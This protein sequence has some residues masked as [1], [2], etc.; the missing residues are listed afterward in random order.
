VRPRT[1]V[2]LY[3]SVVRAGVSDKYHNRAFNVCVGV[4][5]SSRKVHQ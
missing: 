2:N 4:F 1:I 5:P 3:P